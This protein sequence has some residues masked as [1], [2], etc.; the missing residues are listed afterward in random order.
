[1]TQHSEHVASSFT[2][3]HGAVWRRRVFAALAVAV[4]GAA[5]PALADLSVSQ[6]VGQLFKA[7]SSR[8]SPAGERWLRSQVAPNAARQAD[9][10]VVVQVPGATPALQRERA[11]TLRRRLAALG[12]SPRQVYLEAAPREAPRTAGL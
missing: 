6:P 5:G 8:L 10:M 9:R 2:T 1:M 11:D 4:M 12:V 7:D 3:G